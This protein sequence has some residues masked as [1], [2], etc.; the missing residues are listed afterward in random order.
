MGKA[1]RG[2]VAGLGWLGLKAGSKVGWRYARNKMDHRKQT[3]DS[4]E[5]SAAAAERTADAAE[6]TADAVESKSK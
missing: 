6:R 5:R 3:A 4:A 1:K 2:A